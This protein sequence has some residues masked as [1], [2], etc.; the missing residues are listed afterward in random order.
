M[1]VDSQ[2]I[3]YKLSDSQEQ[4]KLVES[5]S[6]SD[7]N[8]KTP[9]MRFENN[10]NLVLNAEDLLQLIDPMKTNLKNVFMDQNIKI[11]MPKDSTDQEMQNLKQI[12]EKEAYLFNQQS[13]S[14][15][16]SQST[17]SQ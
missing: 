7:D 1:T 5:V 2:S 14:T 3:Q 15:Q 8:I 17:K 6:K 13:S 12:L 10:L 9:S 16:T 11:A 4:P